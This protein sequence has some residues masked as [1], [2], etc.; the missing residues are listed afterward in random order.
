MQWK[1]ANANF[2][3]SSSGY[4]TS[5]SKSGDFAV[6]VQVAD[7][8]LCTFHLFY[9]HP[10]QRLD[11]SRMSGICRPRLA[12]E[13]KQWRKDHPF[14]SDSIPDI[15]CSGLH[16]PGQASLHSQRALSR[17][18]SISGTSAP[19]YIV[20]DALLTHCVCRDS[21]QNQPKQP[22]AR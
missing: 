16:S 22:T 18:W 8:A 6:L 21:T 17:T 10:Q 13:R 3:E 15:R 20:S 19:F 9:S 7:S 5:T 2:R 14:V 12:E 1:E 11:T 4:S